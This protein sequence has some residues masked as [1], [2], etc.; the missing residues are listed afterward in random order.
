MER[1]ERAAA[2]DPAASAIGSTVERLLRGRPKQL[3]SGAWLGHPLHP[4]LTD[5]PIG[6][7]TT[8]GVLDLFGGKRSRRT[9]DAM[10][11]LGLASM[12]P[13][14]AAG[15]SDWTDGDA[16]ARRVGL[17]HAAS[18]IGAGA[19]YAGA[20]GASLRGKR[21]GRFLFAQGG[22]GAATLGAYVGADLIYRLGVGVAGSERFAPG[23]RA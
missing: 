8:S 22:A 3:L 4:V 23:P 15:W 16:R 19:L 14:A 13:S 21:R 9:S 10:I 20:L 6:F 11:A 17:L 1:L 7:W 18:M 5:L 12:L 2:L